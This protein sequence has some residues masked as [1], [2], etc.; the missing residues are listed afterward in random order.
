V[1]PGHGEVTD[2]DTLERYIAMLETVRGR[3]AKMISDGLTVEEVIAAKP[4]ADLDATFG[5]VANSLGFVD[6][7]YASLKKAH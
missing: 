7:V 4:T 1:I 3:I 5:D 6:R 2:M